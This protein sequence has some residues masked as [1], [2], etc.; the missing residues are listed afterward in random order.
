MLLLVNIIVFLV[1]SNHLVLSLSPGRSPQEY[2]SAFSNTKQVP[3]ASEISWILR[4]VE[5]DEADS[6]EATANYLRKAASV[7][8]KIAHRDIDQS[9][10]DDTAVSTFDRRRIFDLWEALDKFVELSSQSSKEEPVCM[11]YNVRHFI[12][13][14]NIGFGGIDKF[15][16]A[17]SPYSS[18]T[19]VQ[20]LKMFN[21][22]K[23]Y[24]NRYFAQC[25]EQ[26]ESRFD[27]NLSRMDQEVESKFDELISMDKEYPP[28][29]AEEM[30]LEQAQQVDLFTNQFDA[31]KMYN[32]I[33]YH[34][35]ES[36]SE[37]T[38]SKSFTI[39]LQGIC[40]VLTSQL[41]D[42]YDAYNLS[43]ALL[44]EDA[45]KLNLSAR[46][47]K[48][49]EYVRICNQ[50]QDPDIREKVMA[51]IKQNMDQAWYKKGLEKLTVG[52]FSFGLMKSKFY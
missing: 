16:A 23:Y 14:V 27:K 5:K 7:A 8:E 24:G 34:L 48:L 46:F 9:F 6:V 51:N 49:N 29:K 39:F 50:L 32:S 38:S 37:Y 19:E 18:S 52:R 33:K 31:R 3:Q 41:G 42:V 22:L 2:L 43:R 28:S 40:S 21:Y 25:L 44:P 15:L 30:L 20:K 45:I 10:V 26:I 36:H 35:P 12:G 11:K 47:L 1:V 17:I 4:E 13:T